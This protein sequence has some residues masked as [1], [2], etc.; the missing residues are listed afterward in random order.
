MATPI[1]PTRP[2]EPPLECEHAERLRE[3]LEYIEFMNCALR[4]VNAATGPVDLPVPLANWLYGYGWLCGELLAEA[5]N[6]SDR[7]EELREA[8]KPLLESFREWQSAKRVTEALE[9]QVAAQLN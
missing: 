2:T 4:A 8:F 7:H 6:C 5:E 9:A 3:A 1:R